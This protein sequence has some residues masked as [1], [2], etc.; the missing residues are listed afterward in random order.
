[1]STNQNLQ[2]TSILN[3]TANKPYTEHVMADIRIKYLQIPHRTYYQ[4]QMYQNFGVMCGKL[5]IL[6]EIMGRYG[7][8]TLSCYKHTVLANLAT[9]T[10]QIIQLL[11]RLQA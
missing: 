10:K 7:S 8:H 4:V 5:N 1:M 6:V 9:L 3:A 2:W 11:W